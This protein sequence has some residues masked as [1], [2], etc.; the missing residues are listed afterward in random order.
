MLSLKKKI[1]T[2]N[3]KKKYKEIIPCGG[4]RQ[5]LEYSNPAER[6]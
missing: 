1:T 2:K 5:A 4:G 6:N 3:T